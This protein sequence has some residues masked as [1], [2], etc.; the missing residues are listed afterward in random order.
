M[1]VTGSIGKRRA[2]LMGGSNLI[3]VKLAGVTITFIKVCSVT[4]LNYGVYILRA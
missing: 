3:Y 2:F 1:I 4:N